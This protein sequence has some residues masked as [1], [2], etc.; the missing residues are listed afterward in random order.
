MRPGTNA[1]EAAKAAKGGN[2]LSIR[3]DL[4][5]L[6]ARGD[7]S[8]TKAEKDLLKW[9]GLFARVRTPGRFMLR[10]R[11]PNGFATSE[12]LRAIAELSRRLG[13]SIVDLTTRQQVEI[14]GFTIETVPEIW[15]KLRTVDLH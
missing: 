12:Q 7:Q 2:P 9:L 11:M 10:I 8:L 1:I 5:D 14:R 6:I 4:P 13:N 15:E 3:D